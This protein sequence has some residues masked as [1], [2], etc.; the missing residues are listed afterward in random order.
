[1]STRTKTRSSVIAFALAGIALMSVVLSGCASG[2][3]GPAPASPSTEAER[4]ASLRGTE[5]CVQNN[6]AMNMRITWHG[7][8]APKA[9]PP[10]GRECHSGYVS[11]GKPDVQ[12]TIEYEPVSSSNTW[13]TMGLWATNRGS[14]RPQAAT[15]FT[16][17][18]K[19]YGM[20][21]G[22]DVEEMYSFAADDISAKLTRI[23]DTADNKDFVLNLTDSEGRADLP[24]V[25]ECVKEPSPDPL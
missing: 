6:S 17:G 13:L 8:D 18:E 10:A 21:G 24:D 1:M 22:F 19:K 14:A 15:W 12:A 4:E 9:L 16:K 7:F 2:A 5:V 3:A 11:G 23:A 25:T 20:C